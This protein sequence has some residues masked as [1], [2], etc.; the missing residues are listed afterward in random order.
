MAP[1][2]WIERFTAWLAD[3]DQRRGAW[4]NPLARLTGR[5][6]YAAAALATLG[7]VLLMVVAWRTGVN[8]G[9]GQLPYRAPGAAVQTGG[10]AA[11]APTV[12]GDLGTQSS[13]ASRGSEQASP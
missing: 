6:F 7:I 9:V 4:E 13:S 1:K 2:G 10:S 11:Y 12:E 8:A 3:L 5:E